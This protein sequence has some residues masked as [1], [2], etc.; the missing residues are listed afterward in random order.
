MK[1]LLGNVIKTFILVLLI[2]SF[3]ASLAVGVLVWKYPQI[4]I[5]IISQLQVEE[6]EVENIT[7]KGIAVIGDSQSDEYRADDSR[8]G[9]YSQNTFNW[10]ELLAKFRNLN[11]GT[12]DT[13]DEPRRT[14]YAYNFARTGATVNSML[15]S[16]QDT[17][18]SD[19]VKKGD[20]NVVIIFIGANDFSPYIVS[21]GYSQIYAGELTN[22][23]II[24]K[25]N[26]LVAD[27]LT[28]IEEIEQAGDAKIILVLLPDW[29]NHMGIQLA[30]PDPGSR[31]KVKAVTDSINEKLKKIALEKGIPTMDP[32][33]VY[34]EFRNN[35][36]K[37]GDTTMKNY[38]F[39]NDPRS[40]FLDDT[41]HT[42]TVM[43]SLFANKI[44][45]ILNEN[46]GANRQKFSNRE[47]LEIANIREDS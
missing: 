28:A 9:E 20:V 10:V 45:E 36:M 24:R 37:I 43:N 44:I 12:W 13:Y 31:A 39:N 26:I 35:G 14:G 15:E 32:N 22:K 27:I 33:E 19:L 29:G 34:L 5:D 41:I 21:D 3:I 47:I 42:G 46:Y 6:T 23:Q 7:I 25:S 16:G 18:V 1:N 40:V 8:G 17:G 30:F 11:F 2:V 4:A 38:I